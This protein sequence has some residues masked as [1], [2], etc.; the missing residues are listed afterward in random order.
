MRLW[1]RICGLALVFENVQLLEYKIMFLKYSGS[2]LHVSVDFDLIS[3][4]PY[5]DYDKKYGAMRQRTL[6][7]NRQFERKFQCALILVLQCTLKY[8]AL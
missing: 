6:K 8:Y 7:K 3:I 5:S 1:P 2:F 4:R